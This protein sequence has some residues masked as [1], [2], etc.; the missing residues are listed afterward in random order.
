MVSR[1]LS[2][3]IIVYALGSRSPP[4]GITLYVDALSL[5]AALVVVGMAAFS[6]LYAVPYMRKDPR[7]GKFYTLFCLQIAG[8]SGVVLTGDM[9]NLYVFFEI[10]SVST[11][12]LVAY[13]RKWDS[14]EAAF[15][16]LTL[17]GV[18]STFVLFG[19]ALLY[20]QYQTLNMVDLAS[21]IVMSSV[22]IIA[23]RYFQGGRCLSL[24]P[25]PV[26]RV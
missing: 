17:G 5:F 13:Q 26:L 20:A 2:G 11:Y 23:G 10:M 15:K 7:R 21:K 8:I 4:Y 14:A 9:F 16:L 18:V 19:V 22:D 1:V 25:Y 6:A 3:D 24:C 12:A